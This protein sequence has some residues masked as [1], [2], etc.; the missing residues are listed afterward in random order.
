MSPISCVACAGGFARSDSLALPSSCSSSAAT[1]IELTDGRWSEDMKVSSGSQ[2]A[3]IA[4]L[5]AGANYTHTYKLVAGV[6]A[7]FFQAAA[8]LGVLHFYLWAHSPRASGARCLGM[9]HAC[10]S[11]PVP[12]QPATQQLASNAAIVKYKARAGGAEQARA[13]TAG[14]P[15]RA[16][17]QEACRSR[18]APLQVSFSVPL[19]GASVLSSWQNIKRS[20]LELGGT[21]TLG[22]ISTQEN[23]TWFLG[24]VFTLTALLCVNQAILS[25]KSAIKSQRQKKALK[26]L[27]G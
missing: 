18:M 6:R 11:A 22:L 1:D 19:F 17:P 27:S 8:F 3:K 9:E 12:A 25:T 21:I 23:W 20:L 2:S 16:G 10:T 26:E 7:L 5:A 13:V 24:T 4:E 15:A 14:A